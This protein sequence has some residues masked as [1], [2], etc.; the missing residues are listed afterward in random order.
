MNGYILYIYISLDLKGGNSL[1]SVLY[2]HVHIHMYVGVCDYVNEPGIYIYY[3]YRY[4]N[5]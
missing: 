4:L 1:R 2:M 5:S 3:I